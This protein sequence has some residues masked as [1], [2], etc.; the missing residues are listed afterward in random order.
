[1]MRFSTKG[2]YGARAMIDLALH[3]G[4]GP[5]MI[6][7][8]AQRQGIS[9]KYLEQLLTMLRRAGI[10]MSIQGAKGGFL[11]ARPPTELTLLDVLQTLEGSLSPVHCLDHP[12]S[13]ERVSCC[14]TMEIWEEVK[15]SVEAVLQNITLEQL[16]KRHREVI[17]EKEVLQ[18]EI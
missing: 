15:H 4:Q 13:C 18:Y 3:Y 16:V 14:V 6:K 9:E 12:E 11:L 10:I 1:M 5:V 17:A 7:D 2:R 8:I